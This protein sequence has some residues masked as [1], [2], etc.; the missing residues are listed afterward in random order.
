VKEVEIAPADAAAPHL[1]D[2]L[3]GARP[4]LVDLAQLDPAGAGEEGSLH[5][6]A[7]R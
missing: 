7:P 5:G 1:D 2:D 6:T 3:A 4:R